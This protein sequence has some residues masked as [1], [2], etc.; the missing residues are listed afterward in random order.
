MVS[1]NED[2]P[3]LDQA[4]ETII[5]LGGC[6]K[7]Q[8]AKV[9]YDKTP[10]TTCDESPREGANDERHGGRRELSELARG[11]VRVMSR[12]TGDS[13]R[14]AVSDSLVQQL[15]QRA[16]CSESNGHRGKPQL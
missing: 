12:C 2:L 15:E 3:R 13:A 11:P 5:N 9:V 7:I 16:A 14:R 1:L 6:Q 10:Y 4:R 8:R